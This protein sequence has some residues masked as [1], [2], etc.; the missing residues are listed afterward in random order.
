M[1]DPWLNRFAVLTASSTLFLIFVG[2]LVTSTGSGLAVPDWP[3]SYG[4]LM[5]PMV[6][7]VFFEHG[8]RMVAATVGLLTL[9]LAVWIF[10]RERRRWVGWLA[11]CALA[12]VVL[13]GLLGGL[14][15]LL[16]LPPAVSVA[17]ACL[18]QAFFCLTVTL[19]VVTGTRWAVAGAPL[20]Q[21][22]A[23]RRLTIA[24]TVA[25]YFQLIL[26][27]VMRHTGA[28]L[29]IP[30]F[31]LALGRIIPPLDTSAVAIHFAH[32]VWAAFLLVLGVATAGRVL[33]RHRGLAAVTRPAWAVI[34]LLV[35]QIT[36]GAL[37]VLTGKSVVPTT[38][39]VACGAG[40]LAASLVL[41]LRVHRLSSAAG[42]V[43]R[44]GDFFSLTK[45][46]VVVMILL[47]T[48]VGFL[49]G[50]EE[51]LTM[52]SLGT[53]A[54]TLFG[55][56]MVAGGTLA[57][58][59]YLERGI[60]G[61]M[62]RTAKRPLPDGRMKPEEALLFGGALTGSGLLYLTLFVNPVSGMVTALTV[63]TYLFMYTPLK[64]RTALCTIVG[65]FPG[66][67]PPLTGWTAAGAEL[68]V[69]AGVL[70]AMLFLWQLPHSLAIAHL[71]RE[72][73]SR[74]GV[75]LLPTVDWGGGSTG[76]HTVLNALALLAVGF[77]PLLTG[78]A[79]GLYAIAAL[80]LG[81]LVLWQGVALARSCTAQ[82]ARRLLIATYLYI[83]I[84]LL[85]MLVDRTPV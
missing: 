82:R 58:N 40:L 17:H 64:T 14:T 32:R 30:D 47:T 69:G 63:I 6:G 42:A 62:R 41:T 22:W 43:G 3:L 27:A 23:L 20:G 24:F 55:T 1:R 76:R 49:M 83:P 70:F 71:Y 39:H 78:M 77:L 8:H 75:R 46:R 56:A 33:L 28:G 2:G 31:P 37:T 9:V 34:V 18:A 60:D 53:L 10:I 50:L 4:Q 84:V 79:G 12:A 38:A 16:L 5:P 48:A 57:L 66:A 44:A 59:Q 11:A 45:P 19:A 61:K 15:V 73:Y 51:T 36:L 85:T 74:A 13:Q 21:A 72:D 80:A 26:G 54:Q 68:G 7:G 67:L 25:V 65:A 35:T 81:G 52:A 29:A